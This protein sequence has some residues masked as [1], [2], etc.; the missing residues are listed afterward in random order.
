MREFDLNIERVLENWTVVHALREVIANALDEQALTATAEPVIERDDVGRWHIRDWGRGLAYE[1]LTQNE[2]KEKLAHPDQVVGKFGVG[3]KDALATFERHK[4]KVTI[5]SRHADMSTARHAKH[6]FADVQTLHAII[7]DPADPSQQGTDFV[8]D[9]SAVGEAQIRE[10]KQLFLRYAGDTVL[11]TTALGTV[12]EPSGSGGRIYV[13]GLRVAT[14]DN[15]LF[16][17]DITSSTPALR[18]ALNR[19]RSNVGRGAYTDRVK[20]ILTACTQDV[21]IEALV[22]DLQRF[23]RGNQHD[24]T[25]WLDIGVHAC[26]QLNATRKVIFLTASDLMLAPDFLERAKNDGYQVVVVPDSIA[27]KL[28]NLA[29]AKGNP[30]R[31]LA[32]YRAEWEES[33]EFTFVDPASLTEAERVVWDALPAIFA[34][35][36][37]RPKRVRDV[38]ISET[39]RLQPELYTEAVGVWEGGDGR[40]VVKR[41]QLRSL[42]AF[43]GTVLHELCHAMSGASDV[44][45]EFEEALTKALG[46]VVSRQITGRK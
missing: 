26:R 4:V 33:F 1:H 2:N 39:M 6:G 21:V 43:A 29:D 5:T 9:G 34:A 36:G 3:L 17:Y 27:R 35:G 7:S 22:A 10:A 31:D 28:P 18:R 11:G 16:S 45:S 32:A 13:N 30:M 40:I 19:E 41:N 24:E 25:G 37:G 46:D 8:L 14:E 12:L 44:T 20:A 15:F 38:A 23:Q 42:P